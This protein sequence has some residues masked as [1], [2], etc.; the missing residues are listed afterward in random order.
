MVAGTSIQ[1]L[2]ETARLSFLPACGFSSMTYEMVN[3]SV[4]P[5][6]ISRAAG[7]TVRYWH[8]PSLVQVMHCPSLQACSHA[9]FSVFTQAL[10]WHFCGMPFLLHRF[11]FSLQTR[12]MQASFGQLS[13][14][15]KA[16]TKESNDFRHWNLKIIVTIVENP[17]R[18]CRIN[19]WCAVIKNRWFA[20]SSV[21]Y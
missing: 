15:I 18:K 2:L 4:C 7:D 21:I 10:F 5:S 9:V 14:I 11:S 16:T 17:G 3:V 20:A 19:D 1:S 12:G 13:T 8:V 6:R